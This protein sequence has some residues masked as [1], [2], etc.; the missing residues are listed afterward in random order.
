MESF[1]S[2]VKIVRIGK[3]I[4]RTRDEAKAEVFYCI[5]G[6]HNPIRQHSTIRYPSP[7]EFKP[8]GRLP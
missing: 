8:I 5:E 6:F 2:S 1:L 7:V 3:K 4:Y